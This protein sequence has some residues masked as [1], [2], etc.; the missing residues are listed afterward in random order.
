VYNAINKPIRRADALGH[1]TISVYDNLGDKVADTA[2]DTTVVSRTYD[3]QGNIRTITDAVGRTTMMEYDFDNRL[4]KTTFPDA[5]Y[6]TTTYDAQG[7]RIRSVDARG[8]ETNYG[9]DNAGHNTSVTDAL[10]HTTYFEYDKAGRKTAMVDALG[11]RTDYE[12]DDYDRLVKTTFANGSTTQVGYDAAGRK[13]SET[14]PSGFT[15]HFT[16]DSVGNLRAVID[17]YGDSTRYTYDA[18]NNR[19]TQKDANN[20]ITSMAY[21]ALNRMVSRTY[22]NGDQERWTYDDNGA[23]LSHVKGL[24][25][26][27]YAYDAM[28]REISRHHSNSGRTVA[29]TYTPDGKRETVTDYRG[30]TT[31]SYDNRGRLAGEGYPNGDSL[32]NHYDAQGNRTSVLTP[33]GTTAYSYDALNRMV[34]VVSP[35]SKTTTYHYDAVGNRDSVISPNGTTSGYQYDNLNRLTRMRHYKAGTILAHYAY[36]LN[37]AGIRTQVTEKDSSKAFFSY[38][39]LYR[40]KSERRTGNHTDTM[41]YTY[42]PVGNRLA[43]VHR[44]VTTTYAYNNRDQL[45]SEWDGSDSTRYS[46]DSAGR[47]LTKVETGGTTHYRWRDEDRLDSLY[48]SGPSAK[49]QYD[50]DGRRVK[51][52]TGSTVRQYLIDPL[53]PYG[54]VIAETNGS[55]SLI[56]EYVYGLDR[57]SLRRSGASHYYLADGQGSIRM[58]TDST[59]TVTDSTMYSAFGETLFS[60]GS[61]PNPFLYTGEQLDPNSGFYYNRARWYDSRVGRFASVDPFEGDPQ[62]PISLHRYLYANASPV[63]FTD[64]SGNWSLTEVMETFIVSALITQIT[65][66][67]FSRFSHP[68]QGEIKWTGTMAVASHTLGGGLVSI[69]ESGVEIEAHSTMVDGKKTDARY[70]GYVL[71]AST[72]SLFQ[73]EED[74][75]ERLRLQPHD[76]LG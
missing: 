29:T 50:A 61:T 75:L 57:V 24:D 3:G 51:D 30:V 16:Y 60:S 45:L 7:R 11:H 70:L 35:Q 9:Y 68:G 62:A 22:P 72:G 66:T 13:V 53:L 55:D 32:E 67:A 6:T 5:H 52:S 42:D 58:L 63:N 27:D 20:H 4:V 65:Q 44:G 26:T 48:G 34:S 37:A 71:G 12:Y 46:Y 59:G 8:N 40:L 41:T 73:K 28:G 36:T 76:G 1:V 56:N 25:S 31:F 21:D 47:M 64:P 18:K 43:K 54:Q 17:A 39:N 74:L 14:D 49:Y 2:A 19:L 69:E 15:T 38:D 23:M 10:G 33:F